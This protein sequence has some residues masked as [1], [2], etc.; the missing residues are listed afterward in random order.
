MFI[1]VYWCPTRFPC[2]MRFEPFDSNTTSVTGG[3]GT[4]NLS[5]TSLFNPGLWWGSC[6]SI[7]SLFVDRCLSFCPVCY[8]HYVVCPSL[9]YGFTTL[10]SS[11]SSD[12][13]PYIKFCFFLTNRWHLDE[14]RE[15]SM[16]RI[17]HTPVVLF[18]ILI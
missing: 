18:Y 13:T 6:C 10:V 7:F 3:A 16:R 12:F 15:H 17:T 8:G 1:Y 9:I 4:A 5:R 11:T 2:Q 14:V